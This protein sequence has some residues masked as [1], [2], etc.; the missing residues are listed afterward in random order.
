LGAL[1]VGL[2]LLACVPVVPPMERLDRW[3]FSKLAGGGRTVEGRGTF[4][5]PRKLEELM[6][7]REPE[8]PV[9]L[10]LQEDPEQWFEEMPPPPADL[11]VVFSRLHTAGVKHLGVGYP[12]QWEAGDTLAVETMRAMMD[13]FDALALGLPLKDGT[14]GEPVAAPF[15]RASVAY[16]DVIG[17]GEDLPVVNAIR[18]TAPELGGEK[19]LAGFTRLDSE[20]KEERRVYLLAR[21]GDRVV[22]S[23]PVVMEMARRGLGFDEIR[24]E[25]GRELRLGAEGPRIAI[26][27]RGRALL[28]DDAGELEQIPLNAVIA[29]TLPDGFGENSRSGVYLGD[30][31]ELGPKEDLA[32]SSGLAAEARVISSAPVRKA[33]VP[34]P[35]PNGLLEILLVGAV[36]AVSAWGLRMRMIELRLCG[37]L[38]LTAGAWVLLLGW[39]RGL[40]FA[41]PPLAILGL[42]WVAWAGVEFAKWSQRVQVVSVAVADTPKPEAAPAKKKPKRKKRRP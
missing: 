13:R 39:I 28:P 17:G 3:L 7:P 2:L 29:R 37:A 40:G 1:G 19:T 15:L 34:L 11:A 16:E 24:I 6:L 8:S 33:L 32:W 23:L 35:R 18:G 21:W 36:A 38:A 4:S 20:K 25:P 41:P 26:D 31:R 22:F 27:F 10:A 5:E 14:A 9:L 30:G 42:P 12:L